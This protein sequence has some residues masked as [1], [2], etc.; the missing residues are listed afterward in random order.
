[1]QQTLRFVVVEDTTARSG[2]DAH[3]NF[4]REIGPLCFE[5]DGLKAIP[6]SREE[7]P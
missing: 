2:G 4:V 1:M 3:F 7:D 6:S 5:V